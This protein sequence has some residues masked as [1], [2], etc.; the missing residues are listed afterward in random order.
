MERQE[1]YELRQKIYAEMIND[2]D[3]IFEKVFSKVEGDFSKE[4]IYPLCIVE[5]K[6]N[7]M[8][9]K[10]ICLGLFADNELLLTVNPLREAIFWY[11][12][13]ILTKEKKLK[14]QGG[15]Y[16]EFLPRETE[17]IEWVLSG[18]DEYVKANQIKSIRDGAAKVEIREEKSGNLAFYFPTISNEYNKEMIYYYGLDDQLEAQQEKQIFV[19]CEQYLLKK[20]N[21]YE[22]TNNP[23]LIVQ[24]WG[25][26]RIMTTK[27]DDEY[28]RLCKKRILIDINKITSST[29]KSRYRDTGEPVIN[30]KD[31]IA[32]FL[33]L[34]YYLSRVDTIKRVLT[35]ATGYGTGRYYCQY[36]IQKLIALGSQVG[37]SKEVVKC[38]IRYFSIDKSI[39]GGSFTEFPFIVCKENIIWIPSSIVLN[40]FQFSL[41]NGHYYKSVDFYE[42][43]ETV[44]QSIVDYIVNHGQKFKN[45]LIR[46]NY[47][48]DDPLNKYKGKDLKSDI[49]VA[50][51]DRITKKLLILECKW[52]ENLYLNRDDYLKIED[53]IKKIYS[54]QLEKHQFYL[55][56]GKDRI[57][58]IFYD[59][60]NF[61]AIDDLDVLY[62]FVDKRI[63]FHDNKNNQHALPIFVLAHLFEKYS[64]QNELHMDE[65]FKEIRGMESIIEREKVK[66]VNPVKIGKY[67]IE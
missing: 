54:K 30:S 39:D 9:M 48:Y 10:S 47:V 11:V 60:V 44:S 57:S 5:K 35:H 46:F 17:F 51:Y 41:V 50:I 66:L 25:I 56:L 20:I 13:K 38:Y 7:D 61:E 6:F 33:A 64:N 32:S 1:E 14:Y 34:I 43:S 59:K 67:V 49:D 23:Q 53:A 31:E 4:I 26:L 55:S 12:K 63:Q 3:R 37:L 52:K 18:Y 27:I 40:D 62:L 2:I 58:K 29:L 45:L 24:Y 22:L 28:F 42:K 15:G 16:G 21:V 36:K 8:S 65:I 19:E